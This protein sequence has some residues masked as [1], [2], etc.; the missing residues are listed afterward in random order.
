MIEA[1]NHEYVDKT[2]VFTAIEDAFDMLTVDNIEKMFGYLETRF[3]K[4]IVDIEPNKGKSIIILRFCN[5]LLRRLSK[6]KNTVTCGRILIFL[7]SVFPLSER[8]GV[9][10]KGEFNIENVT[11]FEE[12]FN[13][14]SASSLNQKGDAYD[15]DI[16]GD[17]NELKIFYTHLWG[18][19]RYFS[20]PLSLSDVN[21][22]KNFETV[23]LNLI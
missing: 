3:E 12:F 13:S 9:N 10:A 18:L 16:D 23:F 1:S 19:Q 4:L 21:N 11:H 8:S 20:N 17:S 5:E 7:S 2:L 15:M 22:F 6:T 14:E